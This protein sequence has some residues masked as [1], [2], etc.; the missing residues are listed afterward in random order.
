MDSKSAAPF[1]FD[2]DESH[3]VRCIE[4]MATVSYHKKNQTKHQQIPKIGVNPKTDI[5]CSLSLGQV[6]QETELCHCPRPTVLIR[7]TSWAEETFIAL[8]CEH[9]AFCLWHGSSSAVAEPSS[10]IIQLIMNLASQREFV[11]SKC[12]MCA[13]FSHTANGASYSDHA[14]AQPLCLCPSASNRG[15]RS[16]VSSFSH[17][18]FVSLPSITAAIRAVSF[19]LVPSLATSCIFHPS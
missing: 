19:S 1:H 14:P 6:S 7:W 17:A 8:C 3:S 5:T 2:T 10:S 4:G 18:L 12:R 9:A 16:W 15:L 11:C 13:I